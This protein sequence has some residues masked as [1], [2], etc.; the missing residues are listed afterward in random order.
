GRLK[1]PVW[2]ARPRIAGKTPKIGLF[3][4]VIGIAV[5]D[6]SIVRAQHIDLVRDE[7]DRDARNAAGETGVD[8]RHPLQ[9][10]DPRLKRLLRG[11]AFVDRGR[12]WRVHLIAQE[13][14]QAGLVTGGEGA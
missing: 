10:A 13:R 4:R 7:L 14:P 5:D 1:E 3:D 8:D 6:A 9:A 2:V 11:G 12:E